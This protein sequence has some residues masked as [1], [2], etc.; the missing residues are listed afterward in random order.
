MSAE[1]RHGLEAIVADEAEKEA[2]LPEATPPR[3]VGVAGG[4]P[5]EADTAPAKGHGRNGADA[6]RG[7]KRI[8][9][10]HPALQAGDACPV[11]GEGIVYTK[12]PGMLVRISGQPPLTATIYRWQHVIALSRVTAS[13]Y[14]KPA[15]GVEETR[16][17]LG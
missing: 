16:K 5:A 11:C 2:T 1:E 7:A 10:P 14:G 17:L 8:D 9:V 12:A 13:L 4:E 6:Y 3:D 15:S